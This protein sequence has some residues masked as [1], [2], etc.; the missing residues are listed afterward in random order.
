MYVGVGVGDVVTLRVPLKP[1]ANNECLPVGV[2]A[3][4]GH[5][6]RIIRIIRVI[7]VIRVIG[8]F[9]VITYRGDTR[10]WRR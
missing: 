1:T 7:R 5:S 2:M 4:C 8:A 3:V 6:I 10:R 9:R